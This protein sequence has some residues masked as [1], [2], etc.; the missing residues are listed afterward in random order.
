MRTYA[1]GRGSGKT[2]LCINRAAQY[3][4]QGYQVYLVSP[5]KM[6]SDHAKSFM[7]VLYKD[8]IVSKVNFIYADKIFNRTQLRGSNDKRKNTVIIFDDMDLSLN[9]LVQSVFGSKA[10]VDLVTS[11]EEVNYRK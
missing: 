2:T 8:E 10:F 3:A 4:M 7:K 9:S 1:A 5:T 11:T 6:M